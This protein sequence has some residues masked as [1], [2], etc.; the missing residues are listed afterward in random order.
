MT[1]KWLGRKK[2]FLKMWK[3]LIAAGID[4][5]PPVPLHSNVYLGCGQKELTPEYNMVA[6]KSEMFHRLCFQEPQANL[7]P[8]R[9]ETL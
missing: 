2:T 6:T 1:I 9:G 4:L 5:E 8:F 7:T 3:A